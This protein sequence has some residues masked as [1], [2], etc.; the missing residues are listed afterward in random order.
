[1]KTKILVYRCIWDGSKCD[2][3]QISRIIT[4]TGACT[5]FNGNPEQTIRTD[6]TGSRIKCLYQMNV[7]G[8]NSK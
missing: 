2:D 4:D 8:K 7:F 5:T 6:K 3:S 1:M